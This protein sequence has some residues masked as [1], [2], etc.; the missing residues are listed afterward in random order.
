MSHNGITSSL[1]VQVMSQGCIHHKTMVLP[2]CDTCIPHY[3][4]LMGNI[5]VLLQTIFSHVKPEG[6]VISQAQEPVVSHKTS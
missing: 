3:G 4:P 6:S 1:I 2:Y 5:G